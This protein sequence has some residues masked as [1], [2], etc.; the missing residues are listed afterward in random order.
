MKSIR[1]CVMSITRQAF[2]RLLPAAT[3]GQTFFEQGSG[4][5]WHRE[6]GKTWQIT[7]EPVSPLSLG[8]LNL[9][10]YRVEILCEGYSDMEIVAFLKRFDDHFQRGGG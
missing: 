7:L 4:F 9:E 1:I 2:L 10:R 6:G 3:G 8:A 5:F